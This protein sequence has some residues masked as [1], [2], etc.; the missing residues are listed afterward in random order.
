MTTTLASLRS[1]TR[2]FLDETA[3][4]GVTWL[5]DELNQYINDAQAWL[6]AELCKADDSFGLRE[7]TATLVQAQADYIYPSD[8]LGSNIRSLYAYSSG[9]EWKKVHRK[10]YEEVI[11][12]GVTQ[13][14]YPN[15]YCAMDLYFKVGPP[16]SAAGY[17]LRMS[18]TRKPT[19]MT[20]DGSN[21]D[22]DD[23]YGALIACQA[24]LLALTRTG[25][26][27]S[28]I[29]KEWKKLYDAAIGNTGP[30]D[31]LTATPLYRYQ[32]EI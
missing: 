2:Y 30:D 16:P 28:T 31:L 22:S 20:Q 3:S 21:M 4:S 25:G 5:N 23:A 1:K 26:D 11:A 15:K 14:D 8:I 18:Y 7:A 17:T 12:E 10:N 9:G 32:N 6:W 19:E 27:K 13:A 29:E 24:A